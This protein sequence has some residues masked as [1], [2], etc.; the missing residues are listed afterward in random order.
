MSKSNEKRMNNR[1]DCHNECRSCRFY[2]GRK[3]GCLT[4]SCRRDDVKLDEI[5]NGKIKRERRLKR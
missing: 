5:A 1:R 2:G 4:D 3:R